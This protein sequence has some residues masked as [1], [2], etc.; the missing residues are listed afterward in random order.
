MFVADRPGHQRRNAN[1]AAQ[2]RKEL[3]WAPRHT[4]EDGLAAT[5][6]WYFEHRGWCEQVQAG[7]YDRQRLGLG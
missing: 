3:R 4:F 7:R 6:R 2:N 1:D 5:A